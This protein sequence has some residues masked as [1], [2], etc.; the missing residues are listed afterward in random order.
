M[1]LSGTLSPIVTTMMDRDTVNYSI[2]DRSGPRIKTTAS[3]TN[4]GG[5]EKCAT[6]E[7]G[8]RGE[9]EEAS[10]PTV[11]NHVRLKV[12]R[13]EITVGTWNV[14]TLNALGKPEELDHEMKRYRWSVLGLAEVRWTG[15]GETTTDDGHT[16]W[17]SGE[18]KLHQK[19]VGFLVHKDVVKSVIECR[20]VSSRIITMR[21]AG[22]P[23]NISIVQVYA[24]T[25]TASDQEMEQFYQQLQMVMKTIM[26]NDVL[27]VMGDWNAKV[28]VD[29]YPTWKGTAGKFGFGTTN[30]R[31]ST[32]L[33]F[34][35]FHDL[36]VTNTLHPQKQSWKTT[37]HSPDGKTHNMIDHILIN[38][39]FQ[40]GVNLA[41]T[42]T[43]TGAGIGSDHDL[44]M[45]TLRV[46]LKRIKKGKSPRIKFDLEKLKDPGIAAE[47]Q[48]KIGGKFAPLLAAHLDIDSFN[49]QLNE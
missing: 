43:F 19:G 33:E 45:T 20:P 47:F 49:N 15:I 21:M 35:K 16:L 46:K 26:K 3:P 8:G 25:S 29:A 6:G 39:R 10:V 30:E 27:L 14:R 41:Q 22:Q 24:P 42:R 38:K 40:S 4:Q 44:L 37:Y 48:A 12:A 28:G 18:D 5:V 23:F 36:V 34:A 31:G 1:P 32:L 9:E 11:D 17:Y 13:K 7:V 2:L